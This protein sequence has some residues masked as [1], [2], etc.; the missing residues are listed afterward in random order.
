MKKN[1]IFSKIINYTPPPLI[2][3]FLSAVV[4]CVP[5][6]LLAWYSDIVQ[7]LYASILLSI[8][9]TTFP[10]ME[11]LSPSTLLKSTRDQPWL[12]VLIW[13]GLLIAAGDKYNWNILTN[14][15]VIALISFLCV[16]VMWKI[17]GRK[18]LF[19]AAFMLAL[20]LMS[21]YWAAA[22]VKT[23]SPLSPLELVIVPIVPIG[24]GI[25]LSILWAPPALW[26]W[27]IAKERKNHR[28]GGPGM[29]ALAMAILFLPVIMV[30]VFVPEDLGLSQTWSTVSLA[31]A[32]I[33]L[34]A[35][36]SEPLR[37]FLLEWGKLSPDPG[38]SP[39]ELLGNSRREK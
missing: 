14:I 20:A 32:G 30:A 16:W 11:F 31:I 8:L 13:V 37:R 7:D 36:I 2:G 18:W 5:I 38:E 15:G 25:F 27:K 34:S 3:A 24:F 17:I 10:V 39:E 12:V 35:V 9:V 1:S 19:W 22:L 23:D 33:L 26:V 6:Y 4:Y 28:V 21:I 29:Q